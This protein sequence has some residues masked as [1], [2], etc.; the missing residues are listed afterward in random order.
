MTPN[1]TFVILHY[2]NLK[3][4]NK[5][6]NSL[7]KYLSPTVNI[8]IVD[9]GSEKEIIDCNTFVDQNIFVIKSKNNLGFARGNNLGF[10]YAKNK[11][12]AKIII[13][14]NND[15]VFKQKAFMARLY[16]HYREGFDIAGPQIISLN[17][18]ANQ[19]PVPVQYKN[20]HMVNVR[21]IKD[22]ILLTLA[23]LGIDEFFRKYFAKQPADIQ[24]EGGEFQLHGACLLFSGNYLGKY[25]GLYPGTFMYNE[26][27]ILKLISNDRNLKMEYFKDLAVF[28]QEKA[29]TK[30]NY[31]NGKEKRIFYYR[32]SIKSLIKLRKLMNGSET[33]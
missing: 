23:H 31:G 20:I 10:K 27:D 17:T 18:K 4:T 32:E 25:D 21:I 16:E 9:N 24:Y 7:K 8:V 1:V 5:C 14:A 11:L 13:L 28:H 12:K 2:E 26:E 6:V 15:L 3:D 22:I 19:N 29:S 30:H 33:Y